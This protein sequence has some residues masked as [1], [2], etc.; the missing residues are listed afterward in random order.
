LL[1]LDLPRPLPCWWKKVS[2]WEKSY[3]SKLANGLNEIELQFS[4]SKTLEQNAIDR[5]RKAKQAVETE[6]LSMS[7]E[8]AISK[9]IKQGLDKIKSEMDDFVRSFLKLNPP[10]TL[11]NSKLTPKSGNTK[12]GPKNRN[13]KNHRTPNHFPTRSYPKN[14]R[15]PP[16]KQ[17]SSQPHRADSPPLH[18]TPH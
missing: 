8:S 1:N 12:S 7:K 6:T 14:P 11:P 15:F 5:N 16:E 3:I 9:L 4:I 18:K 10:D 2:E 13:I 17:G